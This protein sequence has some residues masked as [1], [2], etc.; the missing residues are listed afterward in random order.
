LISFTKDTASIGSKKKTKKRKNISFVY[1][2]KR[3]RFITVINAD[4]N[5]IKST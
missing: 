3:G 2:G 5:A 4:T 1:Y